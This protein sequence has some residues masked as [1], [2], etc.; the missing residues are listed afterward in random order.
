MNKN[1]PTMP[2]YMQAKQ[3]KKVNT[4]TRESLLL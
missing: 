3:Q 1:P 2:M 4:G